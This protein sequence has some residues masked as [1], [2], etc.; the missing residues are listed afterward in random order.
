LDSGRDQAWREVP[1][2]ELRTFFRDFIND[3]SLC[4]V[5]RLIGRGREQVRKFAAGEIERPHDRTREAMVKLYW[6]IHPERAPAGAV[7]ALREAPVASP[8]PTPLKLILPQGLEKA[9]AALREVFGEVRRTGTG[10]VPALA[11]ALESWLLR[12]VKEEYAA[13]VPYAR[14]RQRRPRR[15]KGEG[16]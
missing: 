10:E 12:R 16:E 7:P 15:K 3:T 5:G 4:E 11:G 13:E 14:P 6:Q 8:T 2:E 1:V 9:T